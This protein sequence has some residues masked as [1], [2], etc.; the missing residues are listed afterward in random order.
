MVGGLAVQNTN[1]IA[2]DEF[3][4]TM[5]GHRPELVNSVNAVAYHPYAP[6]ADAVLRKIRDFRAALRSAGFGDVPIEVTEIGWTTSNTPE[7]TRAA[8]LRR[9][10]DELPRTNCNVGSL[11][12]HT[13][14]T[15]EADTTNPEDWFGIFHANA[16]P[17]PAGES[18]L[19]AVALRTRD[20]GAPMALCASAAPIEARALRRPGPVL[21]LRLKRHGRRGRRLKARLHCPAGCRIAV[22]VLVRRRIGRGNASRIAHRK[23]AFGSKRRIARFRLPLRARVARVRATAVGAHGGSTVRVKRLVLR[24]RRRFG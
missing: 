3:I 15:P 21:Q 19:A 22:D 11:A 20:T 8:A 14:V 9:L 7:E 12:P 24:D 13:W 4:R 5:V 1:V 2:E 18:Y 6:T 23:F 16:T 10:A 17:E